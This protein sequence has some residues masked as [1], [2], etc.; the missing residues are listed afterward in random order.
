MAAICVDAGFLIALY[1]SRDEHH[2]HASS[3][4]DSFFSV[5]S[6]H[7]VLIAPW[8]ILY[9]SLNTRQ[10]RRYAALRQLRID[11]S[12]LEQRQQLVL[13]RDEGYRNLALKD[14]LEETAQD[15]RKLSLPDRVLRA[16]L[17]DPANAIHVLMTY[18]ARDFWDICASEQIRLIDQHFEAG[19]PLEL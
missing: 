8:P 19:Q 13:L 6:L 9:E 11:W 17:S 16:V 10:A 12:A 5:E 15:G 7:H 14:Y 18:N 2:D 3:H 1:D 4:F